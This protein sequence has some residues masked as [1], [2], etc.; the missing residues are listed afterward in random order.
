M[1]WW[2]QSK[3][4]FLARKLDLLLP[5]YKSWKHYYLSKYLNEIKEKRKREREKR[6]REREKERREREKGR[7]EREKRKREEK[8]R[9]EREKRKRE[10]KERREKREEKEK[11]KREREKREEKRDRERGVNVKSFEGTC[12]ILRPIPKT[13]NKQ[14]VLTSQNTSSPFTSSTPPAGGGYQCMKLV[15]IGSPFSGKTCILNKFT[16]DI[17]LEDYPFLESM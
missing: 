4:C 15:F 2:E 7:R 11:R 8:E 10:E 5:K 6:K 9:R 14:P 17:F 16:N 3:A 1:Y 13:N 12:T